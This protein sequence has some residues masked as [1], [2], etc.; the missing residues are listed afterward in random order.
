QSTTEF[1][2]RFLRPIG[3]VGV[4]IVFTIYLLMKR[5]DL[6]YRILLLAGMGRIRIMTQALQDAATRISQYLIFQA[7]VNAAY[8]TSFGCGLFPSGVPNPP[9]G[10]PLAPTLRILPYVGPAPRLVLPLIVSVAVFSSWV[11]PL[12]ITGLFLTL[13]LTAT[14]FVEPW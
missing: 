5:E 6:R 1:L 7:A 2:M 14:N 9:P 11:Q 4:V 10:G 8:G 13:E 3:T 12:L